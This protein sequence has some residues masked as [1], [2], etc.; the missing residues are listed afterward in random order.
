[1]KKKKNIAINKTPDRHMLIFVVV[2]GIIMVL[3]AFIQAALKE[4][5]HDEAFTYIRYAKDFEWSRVPT[6]FNSALAN[7]HWLNT[8]GIKA[9]QEIFGISYNEFLIRCPNLIA[10]IGFAGTVFYLFY[11]KYID[12]ITATLLLL[13]TS[14]VVWFANARGYGIALACVMMAFL[15]YFRW[16]KEDNKKYTFLNLSI[17]FFALSSYAIT[18]VVFLF[19]CYAIWIGYKL[20]SEKKL[21]AYIKR[22][23]LFLV[24]IFVTQL[25]CVIYGI[26][27]SAE[28]KPRPP[29]PKSFYGAMFVNL[30]DMYTDN[31]VLCLMLAALLAVVLVVTL[32]FMKKQ[33]FKTDFL[34]IYLLYLIMICL[35]KVIMDIDYPC[36]RLLIVSAPLFLFAFKEVVMF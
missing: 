13:N 21:V 18:T 36:P 34:G 16:L 15:F 31:S 28:G 25:I 8:L 17:F 26:N 19:V 6:L 7:N 2:S 1:M 5:S 30:T 20:L 12:E 33:L 11:K 23:I 32:F 27:I 22:N 29:A 35:L 14:F 4:I 24:F 3:C 9:I 10:A